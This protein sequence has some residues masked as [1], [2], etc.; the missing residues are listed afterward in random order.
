M[1]FILFSENI[2]QLQVIRKQ[3]ARIHQPLILCRRLAGV[4]LGEVGLE[5]PHRP[6]EEAED[7]LVGVLLVGRLD[8]ES[9]GRGGLHG[10]SGGGGRRRPWSFC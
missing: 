7:G 5:L 8:D 2:F 1:V 3:S 10:C 9:D 6:V 4:D